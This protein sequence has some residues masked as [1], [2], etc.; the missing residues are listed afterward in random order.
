M[1]K[2]GREKNLQSNIWSFLWSS[3]VFLTVR[4]QYLLYLTIFYYTQNYVLVCI[5]AALLAAW[6]LSSVFKI[7]TKTCNLGKMLNLFLKK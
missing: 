1:K 3:M 2:G 7:L 6:F 4:N 5:F